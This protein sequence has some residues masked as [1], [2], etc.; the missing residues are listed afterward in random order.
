MCK[1]V[2]YFD[3][4]QNGNNHEGLLL[5]GDKR[6]VEVEENGCSNQ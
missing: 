4:Q 3:T 1:G 5:A 6:Q 2:E